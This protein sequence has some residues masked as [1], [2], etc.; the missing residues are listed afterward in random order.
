MPIDNPALEAELDRRLS[1]LSLCCQSLQQVEQDHSKKRKGEDRFYASPPRKCPSLH[2]LFTL[3]A[4]YCLLP[5]KTTKTYLKM[6][7]AIKDLKPSFSPSSLVV[8]FEAAAIKAFRTVFP[9]IQVTGC[10]FHLAQS[11]RR[12]IDSNKD[13]KGLKSQLRKDKILNLQVRMIRA[14]AFVPL[15]K[16]L[17]VWGDLTAV[18]DRRPDPMRNWFEVNYVGRQPFRG[19][20][21]S[22]FSQETWNVHARLMA[23]QPKT[24]NS[25]EAFHSALVKLFGCAHPT[26]WKFIETLQ[27]YQLKVDADI[28]N[29]QAG[30][31]IRRV[32]KRWTHYDETK[33]KNPTKKVPHPLMA[34]RFVSAD[35]LEEARRKRQEEWERVRKPDDPEE[36]PEEE[37]DSRSLYERLQEARGK[38]QSEYEE[39]RKMKNMMRGLDSDETDFLSHVDDLKAKQEVLRKKEERELI[40]K[41]KERA[42][43]KSAGV[44][45]LN[46]LR[47]AHSGTGKKAVSEQAQL[48]GAVIRKRTISDV[49]DEP[50]K[51]KKLVEESALPTNIKVIGVI[52]GMQQ[53]SP[54]SDS[55]N[56]DSEDDRNS[57][58]V[59]VQNAG[60]AKKGNGCEEES[61]PVLTL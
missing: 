33:K 56:S 4:V 8:D 23:D 18:L 47:P 25:V 21:L 19:S 26:M 34:D 50:K 6:L 42:T 2:H 27:M 10:F 7:K 46:K 22:L 51:R 30:R 5:H 55:S 60:T 29:V 58:P 32:N 45:S 9:G 52:P 43:F 15:D 41:C 11:Q 31:Q 24:N 35:Q 40:K 1:G 12:Q 53:Y 44:P 38:K 61:F 28:V 37:H 20:N 49:E 57:L 17:E 48:L 16:I 14:M 3:P 39:E 59:L 36:A 13:L 54:S